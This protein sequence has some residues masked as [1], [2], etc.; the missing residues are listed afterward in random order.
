MGEAERQ[1]GRR[2]LS[3]ERCAYFAGREC[4]LWLPLFSVCAVAAP[5]RLPE[6]ESVS[7]RLAAVK[8]VDDTA[9]Y[10]L[11]L[12]ADCHQVFKDAGRDRLPTAQILE[13]LNTSEDRPWG[14]WFHGRGLNA[15]AL[16]FLV[17]G[18]T[19]LPIYTFLAEKPG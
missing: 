18:C 16:K 6:L 11:Q 10:S 17:D 19:L 14:G 9:D 13:A 4:E 12:L 15:Q 2:I 7:L 1:G 3:G 8:S 5:E